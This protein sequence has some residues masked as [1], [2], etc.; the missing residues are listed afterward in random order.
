MS[1]ADDLEVNPFY[2]DA[3]SKQSYLQQVLT[4]GSVLCIPAADSLPQVSNTDRFLDLHILKP[5]PLYKGEYMS[6]WTN[7]N[8]EHKV[9]KMDDQ[10][11]FLLVSYAERSYTI[12]LL[13]TESA[14][15]KGAKYS[16]WLIQRPLDKHGS[17]NG[18]VEM[19]KRL[20]AVGKLDIEH[21]T[22][23]DLKRFLELS[24]VQY[25]ENVERE[26]KHFKSKYIVLHTF[27]HDA[28][29]KLEAIANKCSHD[30]MLPV[31]FNKYTHAALLSYIH[32]R[33]HTYIYPHVRECCKDKDDRYNKQRAAMQKSRGTDTV[34]R[35]N[36]WLGEIKL[37]TCPLQFISMLKLSLDEM[38]S[39]AS[40]LA[41]QQEPLSSDDL[42]PLVIDNLLAETDINFPSIL[43]YIEI[44]G[45]P[46]LHV[47]EAFEFTFATY[48]AAVLYITDY[49]IPSDSVPSLPAAEAATP[50]AAVKAQASTPDANKMDVMSMFKKFVKNFSEERPFSYYTDREN[51]VDRYELL[52]ILSLAR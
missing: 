2:N 31:G 26:V 33:T 47:H 20:T 32:H 14:Y 12:E 16:V 45:E 37:A 48:R 35:K 41:S 28:A 50:V 39:W 49:N 52:A 27:L 9:V 17:P 23:P 42:I 3:L 21:A 11:Q 25:L 29:L 19:P 15:I 46:L 8:G 5:S 30:G 22:L 13:Y 1:Y 4:N 18:V 24:G 36:G 10:G 43:L 44:F 51:Y 6:I 40:R 7:S 38:C 34:Q